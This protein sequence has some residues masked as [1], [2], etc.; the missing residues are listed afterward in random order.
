M[1]AVN[2][3]MYRNYIQL[4]VSCRIIPTNKLVFLII[5][6]MVSRR[7]LP[8]VPRK[9]GTPYRKA[10]KVN[11]SEAFSSLAS[12]ACFYLHT[13]QSLFLID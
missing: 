10:R 4:Y 9:G 13:S 3:G 5:R 1:S 8:V 7:G 2:T 11:Q 12:A 6:L